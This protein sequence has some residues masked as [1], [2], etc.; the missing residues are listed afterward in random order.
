M[1]EL[2]ENSNK[3]N[4]VEYSTLGFETSSH[5]VLHCLNL[6]VQMADVGD[7][8]RE[9]NSSENEGS[10]WVDDPDMGAG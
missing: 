6:G 4:V 3:L 10:S 7:T 9:R 1:R 2:Q 8:L 5:R